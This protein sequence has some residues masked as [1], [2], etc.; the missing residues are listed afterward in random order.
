[1]GALYKPKK[2]KDRL[3]DLTFEKIIQKSYKYNSDNMYVSEKELKKEIV[4]LPGLMGP[5]HKYFFNC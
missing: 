4:I 3:S 2:V 1:M 5:P